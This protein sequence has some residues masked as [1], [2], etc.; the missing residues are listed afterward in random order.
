MEWNINVQILDLSKSKYQFGGSK[1]KEKEELFQGILKTHEY[2]ID[3]Y[4]EENLTEKGEHYNKYYI[5]YKD[6][7]NLIEINNI[8]ITYDDIIIF[9][10][11]KKKELRKKGYIIKLNKNNMIIYVSRLQFI[12]NKVKFFINPLT[13]YLVFFIFIN[14]VLHLM[15]FINSL[16]MLI[17]SLSTAE[18]L[19]NHFKNE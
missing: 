15:G 10:K 17:L 2:I 16:T 7:V 13:C 14:I 18:F 12:L 11:N 5:Y 3:N 6:I 4:I 1:M 19:L 9:L 8:N